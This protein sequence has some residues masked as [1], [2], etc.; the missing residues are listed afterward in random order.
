MAE[1]VAE[2]AQP[3]PPA[4]PGGTSGSD[5]SRDVA[6]GARSALRRTRRFRFGLQ[7]GVL[8]AV[9]LLWWLITAV[10]LVPALYLPSP[11][12][13][14]NAF[15][16]ANSCRPVAEGLT[17]TV[18]GEQ[19]YY[20][21][22]HLVASLQRIGVGVGAAVVVGL[23]AG[24]LMGSSKWLQIAFEPYLNFLRA[25]PPLGY[26]GL[27]IVWLGIGDTS[28]FVLLFLAA[29]PPIVI[30]TIQGVAGV[31][32]DRI[33]AALA[34]GASRAQTIR[35]VVL[36]SSLPSIFSGIRI[37]A[38]FAWTTVVAAELNNGIPGIGALAY[39][40]GTQLNTPLTIACI[41]TIGLV[42]VALDAL[43]VRAGHLLVPWQG[44]A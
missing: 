19:N 2:R 18:C 39:L 29:F 11:G 26:I 6:A 12:A 1:N 22:E 43:I 4:G 31:S 15:I 25:L 36:P 17:R 10:H 34:L 35:Y 3:A 32:G 27:L 37:A 28:K 14:L 13:V 9:L 44:K 7:A 20:L 30:A 41:I 40:S 42:A 38:G 33:N 5:A 24:F 8:V 23:A 21:W 16:Q